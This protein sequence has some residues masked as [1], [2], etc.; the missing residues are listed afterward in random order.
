MRRARIGLAEAVKLGTFYASL[1]GNRFQLAQEVPIRF[2][3]SSWKHEI[4]GL[5]ASL[6][7]SVFDLPNQLRRDRNESVLGGFLFLLA[8]ECLRLGIPDLEPVA[9]GVEFADHCDAVS[10][11]KQPEP[12]PPFVDW[13]S[14]ADLYVESPD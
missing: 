6:S 1:V 3:V 9:S 12:Y 10:S 13:R 4:V 8:S 5:G 2:L 7:H 11:S 14:K